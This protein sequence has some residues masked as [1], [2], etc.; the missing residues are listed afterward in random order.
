M[1]LYLVVVYMRRAGPRVDIKYGSQNVV[2]FILAPYC[3]EARPRGDHRAQLLRRTAPAR[4]VGEVNRHYRASMVERVMTITV[5]IPEELA[6]RLGSRA[7]AMSR[8]GLGL[9]AL[10]E[11]LWTEAELGRFLGL[12]RL[13]LSQFLKDHGVEIPYTWEDL[14]RERELYREFSDR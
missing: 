9:A 3:T 4:R 1:F 14:E 8:E 12:P 10:K 6:A 7:G 2:E 13:A 11:G 5:D